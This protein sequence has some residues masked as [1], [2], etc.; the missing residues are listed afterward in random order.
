MFSLKQYDLKKY[1]V[2][3]LVIVLILSFMGAYVISLVQAPGERLAM[4]QCVGIVLGLIVVLIVSLIDYHFICRLWPLMYVFNL[5]LLLMVKVAGVEVNYSRRWLKLGPVQF[6]PSELS[7]VIMILCLAKFF[8]MVQ[9]RL[10]TLWAIML[11]IIF[12]AVPV[13]LI[14]S[15]PDLSSSMVSV[16]VYVVMIFAAGLSYKIIVPI[17]AIGLPLIAGLFWYVQQDFQVLLDP[18]QQG[19]ILSILNPEKY[20]AL[21]YQ[22]DNSVAAIGSGQLYGKLLEDSSSYRGYSLVPISESDFI[23]SVIGEEFGFIGS[24]VML[25]LFAIIIYKCLKLAKSSM[26]YMGKLIVIGISSMFMF[27]VFV[28]IGVATSML[29]NTGIPLPFVSYGLSSYITN[30]IAIGLVLNISIQRK[31]VRG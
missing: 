20:G 6:Q 1:N 26:D 18:Y 28:N 4:K 5:G 10:N 16:F 9:E 22:Q 12:A 24:C 15:Q 13:V 8:D 30:M 29:P 27:Q 7:K 25:L 3:L 31:K 21:M 17:L 23:F 2:S 19:R 14:M 11:S